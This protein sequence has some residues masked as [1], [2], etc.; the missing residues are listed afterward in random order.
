[1]LTISASLLLLAFFAGPRNFAD[2]LATGTQQATLTAERDGLARGRAVLDLAKVEAVVAANAG[3]ASL[4]T[5][6][7][8]A[9]AQPEFLPQLLAQGRSLAAGQS[10]VVQALKSMATPPGFKRWTAEFPRMPGGPCGLPGL[11]ELPPLGATLIS[12]LL[13][14]GKFSAGFEVTAREWRY[15]HPLVR[16]L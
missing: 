15:A 3:L 14:D 4:Y 11:I 1:M 6:C 8:A 16:T 2:V 10:A 5:L 13:T 9:L 7:P 12:E